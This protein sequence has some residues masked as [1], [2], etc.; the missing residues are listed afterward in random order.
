MARAPFQVLVIPYRRVHDLEFEYAVFRRADEGYW[1]G[2]AGGGE[3]NETAIEAAKRETLEEAGLPECLAFL[4]L[5]TV[6]SVPVT[7]YK[8]SHIWGED[9]YVIPCYCFGVLVDTDPI[10]LSK[11]HIEFK[12]SKYDNAK[13]LL[14]YESDKLA[15]WELDRKLRGL[16]PRDGD[17]KISR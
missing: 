10:R 8:D 14:K 7:I 11:E 12:W 15:L 13:K 6:F 9:L 2:I 16:S 3:G 17:R 4:K 1:H 5:D